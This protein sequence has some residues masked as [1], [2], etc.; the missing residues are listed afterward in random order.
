MRYP[1]NFSFKKYNK[2]R[3]QYWLGNDVNGEKLY[4]GDFIKIHKPIE[5]TQPYCSQ[6]YW[7]CLNGAM[8]QRHPAH[9]SMDK[10]KI[11]EDSVT[12]LSNILYDQEDW[13]TPELL[14]ARPTIVKITYTEYLEWLNETRERYQ[15]YYYEQDKTPI[16]YLIENITKD[17]SKN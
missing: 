3:H 6:I 4:P 12:K 1:K 2:W 5:T 7:Y 10:I 11:D 8:I 13:N 16:D 15:Q 14:H 9:K 17:G